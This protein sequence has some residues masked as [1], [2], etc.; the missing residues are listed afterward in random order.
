MNLPSHLSIRNDH[1][2]IG[3]CDSVELACFYGT[4]LYVTDENR[5]RENFQRFRKA[6][7]ERYPHIRILYAAKANGNPSI[8]KILAGEGAGADVF[9]AGEVQIALMAGMNPEFLLFN[10]SSKTE[11]DHRLAVGKRIRVSL[12]SIDELMQ[13]D[14]IA[15]EEGKI[16]EVSFRVNPAL[17]VPTHPKIATGLATTKFGI[18]AVEI[19]DAYAQALACRNV[20]PIGIHCH[21]GSQIL[22]VEPFARE[23]Q[24]LM[25]IVT[26]LHQMGVNFKFVDLG[27]GLGVCYEHTGCPAPEFDD[28]AAVVMPEIITTFT[29]LGISPEIWVE[30][31]RSMVCDSTILLTKVNSVKKAYKT[32]VN[33][34]AGFNIFLRPAMYDSYHEIIVAN[35]A[36][37]VP[38]TVFTVT[39]PICESGDILAC[40]RELPA[41][42]VGDIIAILD[43]GAYG[44]AMSSQYNGR[45]R[46]A[47][48]LVK[49]D[50]AAL[51][52]RAETLEDLLATMVTP[53]WL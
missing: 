31:G 26:E 5:I 25:E 53:P 19:V 2:N 11:A 22:S 21:I 23:A 45:G 14:R 38:T 15:G 34:D 40:D 51:M 18:P 52:R 12:D 1:L 35:R 4:P 42:E 46:C 30:P 36:D 41:V 28:Y 24:V 37:E 6:L 27:G 33:V 43:T 29:R 3:G 10:G 8:L 32:F 20:V 13:I 50:K 39:G 7:T 17:D 48:V 44:Y 49:G 16:S 47:E 9:S